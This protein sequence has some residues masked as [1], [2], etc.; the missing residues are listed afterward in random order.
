MQLQGSFT[1]EGAEM[2]RFVFTRL[3]LYEL[4]YELFVLEAYVIL[5]RQDYLSKH[6]ETLL[7]VSP[8]GD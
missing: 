5:H 4:N 8:G 2:T 3:N 1:L 6:H 7:F